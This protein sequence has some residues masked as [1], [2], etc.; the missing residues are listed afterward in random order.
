VA[1]LLDSG[2]YDMQQLLEGGWVTGLKYADEVQVLLSPSLPAH[3]KSAQCRQG[4]AGGEDQ[5]QAHCE[6]CVNCIRC[7]AHAGLRHNASVLQDDL[8]T[9]FGNADRKKDKKKQAGKAEQDSKPDKRLTCVTYARYKNGVT[10]PVF[11]A[12][13]RLLAGDMQCMQRFL[14]VVSRP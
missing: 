6:C 13:R 14:A 10:L 7:D 2:T 8:D 12:R 1:K 11:F 5:H 3:H 4:N 9:R